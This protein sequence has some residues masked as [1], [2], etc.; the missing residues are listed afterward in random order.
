M[1]S[2]FVPARNASPWIRESLESLLGQSLPPREI[3]VADD[4]SEDGTADIAESIGSPLIRVLRCDTPEG[5]SRN[6]NE[7]IRQAK[8]RYLAR[9]DADDIALPD[10]FALQMARFR[11][12]DVTVLG[13]WARRFGAAETLHAPPADDASIRAHLGLSSPFVNPTAMFDR[14]ALGDDIFYD[15]DI[16]FGADYDQFARLRH[17]AKFG[18]LAQVTLLWRLHERNA[19]TDPATRVLQNQTVARV[20]G[21]VWKDHGVSLDEA[22]TSALDRLVRLPL[23]RRS[24]SGPLLSAFRKALAH[25]ASIELWAPRPALRAMFLSQWNYFCQVRAWGDPGILPVWRRGIR[26][27]GGR[28]SL[29]V[30]ARLA[31]KALRKPLPAGDSVDRSLD[32]KCILPISKTHPIDSMEDRI[33]G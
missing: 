28:A 7:M 4:A 19:G 30:F 23:P 25:P 14:T 20:R 33:A 15:P 32:H 16:P 21:R 31:F 29:P 18:N 2:V 17:R 13:S 26:D 8:S 27:L 12:S 24:E 1:I 5:I 22:E 6:C 9:M 10:R 3:L 11:S